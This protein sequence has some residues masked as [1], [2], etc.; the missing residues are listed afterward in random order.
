MVTSLV[1]IQERWLS[2]SPLWTAVAIGRDLVSVAL[3]RGETTS[4]HPPV[5][6]LGGGVEGGTH[7]NQGARDLFEPE[8]S[9]EFQ[10]LPPIAA[11]KVDI[12][13]RT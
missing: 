2:G 10:S 1:L 8:G 11:D 7:R 3:G 13:R 12:V 5:P 9:K 4:P 6:W